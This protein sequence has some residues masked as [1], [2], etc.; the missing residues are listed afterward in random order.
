M[1]YLIIEKPY[2]EYTCNDVKT[3]RE[4]AE[5]LRLEYEETGRVKLIEHRAR[6]L[7]FAAIAEGHLIASIIG[8]SRKKNQLPQHAG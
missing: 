1:R 4:I 2:E 8:P 5:H 6:L 3:L 7:V